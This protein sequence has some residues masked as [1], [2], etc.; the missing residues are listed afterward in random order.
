MEIQFI[1]KEK[2]IAPYGISSE[3]EYTP[4]FMIK[5]KKEFFIGNI[6]KQ[7]GNYNGYDEKNYQRR[8]EEIE[9]IKKTLLENNGA[10]FKQ[11]GKYEN[12][13]DLLKW[14][15]KNNYT[16]IKPNSELFR[17]CKGFIDFHGNLKEYSSSFMYRIYDEIFLDKL[18]N[19]IDKLNT[20]LQVEV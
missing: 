20:K 16:F 12:P 1:E 11:H 5:D 4:V 14:I 10:Y 15:I 6:V 9:K 19:E 8:I 17:E 2:Y 7:I 13:F 3:G 18:K